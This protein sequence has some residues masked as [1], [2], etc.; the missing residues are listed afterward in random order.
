MNVSGENQQLNLEDAGIVTGVVRVVDIDGP[1]ALVEP[2]SK[3]GCKSCA[4]AKGCG[5]KMISGY[6]TRNMK[7]I[8]ITNEF[9]GRVGDR[10]EV[11]MENATILKLSAITYMFPLLGM[12]FTTIVGDQLQLANLAIFLMAVFGLWLGF[13]AAQIA[14]SS[15]YVANSVQLIFLGK[16]A[17]DPA[18]FSTVPDPGGCP[19]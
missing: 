3:S 17:S 10:I 4:M 8:K 6:F 19:E 7:P 15:S 14:F 16:L 9:G 11:G 2:E 5:T 1:F 18:V 12:M 13:V